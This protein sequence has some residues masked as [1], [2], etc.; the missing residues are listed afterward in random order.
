MNKC[1]ITSFRGSYANARGGFG[2]HINNDQNRRGDEMR[3]SRLL[4]KR[5]AIALCALLLVGSIGLAQV[6]VS[7]PTATY[8]VGTIQAI[9]ITVGDVTGRAV[10]SF[11][12]TVTYN[13]AILKITGVTTTGTLSATLSSPAVNNDTANGKV[14]IACAGASAMFG[15]GTLIYLNATIVG[16]GTS[17]LTFSNF[18]FNE[19]I[20][21][22]NLTNGQVTGQ[23]VVQ[24]VNPS[25]YQ[26]DQITAAG[27]NITMTFLGHASV[28][29][30]QAGKT[31]Y[32]DPVCRFADFTQ[33]PK[34]DLILI[35]HEHGDHLDS[36]A[37]EMI[38]KPTTSILLTQA[39]LRYV[40]GGQVIR[41]DENRTVQGIGIEAV[42]A[43]NVVQKRS[44]EIPYHPKGV[45][46]G[47]VLTIG[48]V[49]IYFA[50]DT[51]D[52]PEMA[53]INR[54]DFAFLP[55]NVPYTM[56]PA[57]VAAAIKKLKPTVVYPYH[58]GNTN[59]AILLDLLKNDKNT[60][61]RIR[62]LK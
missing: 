53:K 61:V 38:R 16:T 11:Q 24:V 57:M 33:L 12:T 60:E 48:G 5:A 7:L 50:G 59:T 58:F 6:T 40:P 47:Y 8:N 2:R 56:T 9:P 36:I 62:S 30:A 4:R 20:P 26:S 34:A 41:N 32:V 45:G 15:S 31:I 13:K 39:C 19:G 28:M 3:N 18:Q 29:L 44:K 37:I 14:I 1:P 54:I 49:R 43:Y 23:A 10:I 42:P 21:A 46:N 52:I 25:L 27:G 51:E 17:A 35:T 55:M 22:S